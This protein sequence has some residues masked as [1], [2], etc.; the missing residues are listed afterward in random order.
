MWEVGAP[1][2]GAG[3]FPCPYKPN[4]RVHPPRAD[5]RIVE[6][7]E[8]EAHIVDYASLM[9]PFHFVTWLKFGRS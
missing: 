4:L 2:D 9:D 5:Q 1:A 7:A 6:F 8:V 3:G